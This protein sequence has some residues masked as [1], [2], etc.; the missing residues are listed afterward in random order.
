LAARF[1]KPDVQEQIRRLPERAP[2]PLSAGRF[3]F[4]FTGEARLKEKIEHA[5]A[6][7]RHRLPS[8]ELA[9]LLELAVDALIRDLEKT[10]FAV[11]RK[12]RAVR[13]APKLLSPGGS[14]SKPSADDEST[15]AATRKRVRRACAVVVREAYLRDDGCCSFVSQDGRRCG[16]REFLELDHARPWAAGGAS[17]V[18]NLRLRCRAHNQRAAR[19][20]FGRAFVDAAA[21]H[22]QQTRAAQRGARS[23]LRCSSRCCGSSA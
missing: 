11:G 9:A 17:T 1:P 20:H 13:L 19:R 6:L 5:R 10:R 14:D 12:A 4:H 22:R 18:A 23:S 2:E 21:E 3:G 7:A 8:G 15:A 16:S